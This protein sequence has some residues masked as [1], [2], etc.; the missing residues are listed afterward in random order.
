[1]GE[2]KEEK[3]TL[4]ANCQR[5]MGGLIL[6]GGVVFCFWTRG[7]PHG[8]LTDETE[9]GNVFLVQVQL[10]GHQVIVNL[11]DQKKVI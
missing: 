2:N 1:M 10:Y 6:K 11:V 7:C 5:I 3:G 9:H 4:G 8:K